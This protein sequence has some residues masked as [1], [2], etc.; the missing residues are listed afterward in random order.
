MIDL[1]VV[2]SVFGGIVVFAAVLKAMP[3][4][5]NKMKG[6]GRW[7]VSLESIRE[8]ESLTH[9]TNAVESKLDR[10]VT[11]VGNIS[12]NVAQLS[13]DLQSHMEEEE[14][15][16][17]QEKSMVE[18]LVEAV[19]DLAHEFDRQIIEMAETV[20]RQAVFADPVAYYIVDWDRTHEVWNWRWGNPSYFRLTGLTRRQAEGG[21]YWDI[22]SPEERERVFDAANYAGE[23]GIPLEVDFMNVNVQTGERTPVRVIATPLKNRDDETAG[24][25]GSIHV[26]YLERP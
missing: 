22:I 12:H 13:Q 7:V 4:I 20:F 16:R 1:A 19:Q 24:Y 6:F 25:L 18:S 3:V 17:L 26:R 8:I 11:E 14:K 2:G 5:W 21:Q 15:L 10:V 9:E 23:H